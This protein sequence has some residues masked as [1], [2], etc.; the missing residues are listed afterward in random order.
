MFHYFGLRLWLGLYWGG[1]GYSTF[2]RR[3]AM[4]PFLMFYLKIFAALFT[5]TYIRS[6]CSFLALY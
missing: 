6:M 2:A 3:T 1:Y 5:S 4:P